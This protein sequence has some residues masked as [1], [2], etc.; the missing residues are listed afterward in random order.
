MPAKII[1]III[2]AAFCIVPIQKTF[3]LKRAIFPDQ[4]ALQPI[5]TDE[6][7]HP[8][9]SGNINS[10]TDSST[11]AQS[12]Q[13]GATDENNS[14]STLENGENDVKSA[15]VNMVLLIV[16]SVLIATSI[17]LYRKLREK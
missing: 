9:I 6:G 5:P 13:P 8:N 10:A 2:V 17:I 11:S 16:A 4:K 7:A 1:A 14:W 15:S 3:A 12:E